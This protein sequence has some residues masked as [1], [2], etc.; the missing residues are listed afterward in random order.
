[1]KIGEVTNC[2]DIRFHNHTDLTFGWINDGL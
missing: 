1:M 2:D